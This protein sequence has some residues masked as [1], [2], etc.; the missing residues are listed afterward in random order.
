MDD[1]DEEERPTTGEQKQEAL[2]MTTRQKLLLEIETARMRHAWAKEE[3]KTGSPS[4]ALVRYLDESLQELR[5]LRSLA[6]SLRS[7]EAN[8]KAAGR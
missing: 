5:V 6:A 3:L 7:Q 2:A 1:A 8:K 4:P